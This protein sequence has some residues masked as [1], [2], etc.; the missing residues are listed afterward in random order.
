MIN[1]EM[2]AAI[3]EAVRRDADPGRLRA[4]FPG[5]VFSACSE[6]DIPARAKPVFDA[7]AHA[8]YLIA[9][10]DGHCLC[11]TDDLSAASGVVVA[12]KDEE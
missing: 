8:L 6:D 3:G 11:L 2:L 9:S 10:P 5:V 7:G 1:S 4:A 12:G